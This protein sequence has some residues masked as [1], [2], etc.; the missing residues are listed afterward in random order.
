MPTTQYGSL[1][2]ENRNENKSIVCDQLLTIKPLASIAGIPR[3]LMIVPHSF[4]PEC[5]QSRETRCTL[6]GLSTTT[7]KMQTAQSADMPTSSMQMSMYSYEFVNGVHVQYILHFNY[8]YTLYVE[9]W[10]NASTPHITFNKVIE[11]R[12]STL[13]IK[14]S[15]A[16]SWPFPIG[17]TLSA[18]GFQM[19]KNSSYSK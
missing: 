19:P 9:L 12:L 10:H 11:Q 17:Q 5:C 16:C 14:Y 7:G 8:T 6:F 13:S 2:P 1:F 18:V 3:A 15:L 4:N